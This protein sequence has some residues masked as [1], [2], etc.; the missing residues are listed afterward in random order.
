MLP[1]DTVTRLGQWSSQDSNSWTT[2][3]WATGVYTNEGGSGAVQFT[4]ATDIVSFV[5]ALNDAGQFYISVN[6]GPQLVSDGWSG[7]GS[8]ITFYTPTLP[9]T[10]PT[11][12]TTFE[13]YY[14]YQ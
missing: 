4:G 13:Y 11:T 2:A 8:T 1:G 14:Q 5:N 12:V 6:G 7:G 10:D 9:A 3:D